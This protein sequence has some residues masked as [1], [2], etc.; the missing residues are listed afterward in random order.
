MKTDYGEKLKG[1]ID[2]IES[3]AKEDG[4]VPTV[5]AIEA[6][7]WLAKRARIPKERLIT[8]VLRFVPIYPSWSET[9]QEVIRAYKEQV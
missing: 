8:G 7:I 1:I 3:L 2:Q 5:V 6:A 9:E 4:D